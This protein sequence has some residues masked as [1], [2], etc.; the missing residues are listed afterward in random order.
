M[1][2]PFLSIDLSYDKIQYTCGWAFYSLEHSVDLVWSPK[3]NLQVDIGVFHLYVGKLLFYCTICSS[4]LSV[5]FLLAS[6]VRIICLQRGK[7]ENMGFTK[8]E[9]SASLEHASLEQG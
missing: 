5:L 9:G 4:Q 1:Y 3:L 2:L 7:L 6:C 8:A